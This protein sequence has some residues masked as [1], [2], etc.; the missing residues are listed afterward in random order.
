MGSIKAAVVRDKNGPFTVENVSVGDP[1]PDEVMVRTVA[2]GV[3]HTD[4]LVRDQMLPPGPPAI[5]GHEASGIVES[6]GSAVTSAAPGDRVVV[7]PMTCDRCRNCRIGHPMHCEMFMPLNFGGRRADGSTAYQDSSGAELNGHFFGQSSFADYFLAGEGALVKV[8]DEAPMELLGPLG[9]G[10]Q[11]GAGA[12]FNA[13]TPSVGSS[14]VVFGL[15]GVGLAAIMAAR[16]AGCGPIIA[17]DLHRARLDMAVELGATHAVDAGG[18]D[19]VKQVTDLTRGGADFT[20]DAVGI[21]QTARNAFEVLNIGGTACVVGAGGVGETVPIDLVHLLLGRTV[22][23]IIEGDSVPH[24]LIPKLI[25][26]YLDGSFPFD[27]LIQKY[28]VDDI[29]QAVMDSESGRTIKPVV[30]Y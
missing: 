9:C 15:G 27:K 19:V 16:I 13:L 5:L 14:I 17:V 12:V 30:V 3:C 26:F 7:A 4:L 20:L 25:E 29:N 10:L 8:P 2:T 22:K 24:L 23:G 1:R 11:T 21:P 28:S 18:G 6:V